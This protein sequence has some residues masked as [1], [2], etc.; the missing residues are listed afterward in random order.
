MMGRVG[1][2]TSDEGKKPLD[3]G[4][5]DNVCKRMVTSIAPGGVWYRW[6]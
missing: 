2:I 4:K 1:R 5:V 6:I 3:G